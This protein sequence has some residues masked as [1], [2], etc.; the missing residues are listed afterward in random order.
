MI[1]RWLYFMLSMVVL[2]IATTLVALITQVGTGSNITGASLVTLMTL[3]QSLVD[4]I[5]F[6]AALETSIGSVARLR[7]F[8]T[9]TDLEK[10]RR[11][12]LN[13]SQTGH[14]EAR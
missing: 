12:T 4:I 5:Q 14:R 9:Q 8:T 10:S 2:V 1:Q 7:N 13:L 6:Y 11:M 3:S